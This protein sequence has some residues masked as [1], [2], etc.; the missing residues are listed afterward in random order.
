VE[1]LQF[2]DEED[3]YDMKRICFSLHSRSR[4]MA[5][6]GFPRLPVSMRPAKR[7]RLVRRND[8]PK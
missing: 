1:T 6:D 7:K 8:T 2:D 5:Q 4:Q 3:E